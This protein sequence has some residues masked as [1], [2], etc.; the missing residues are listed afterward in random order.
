MALRLDTGVSQYGD[1]IINLSPE[2]CELHGPEPQIAVKGA[3]ISV[4]L[5]VDDFPL[6]V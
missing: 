3:H 5:G 1:V 6:D 2:D 4:E